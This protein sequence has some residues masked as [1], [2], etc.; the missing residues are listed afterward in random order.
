MTSVQCGRSSGA[1][2]GRMGRVLEPG[3]TP[4]VLAQGQGRGLLWQP[5]KPCGGCGWSDSSEAPLFWP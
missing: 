3:K 5:H 4:R 1:G 2:Q